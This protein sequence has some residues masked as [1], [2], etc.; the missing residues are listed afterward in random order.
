MLYNPTVGSITL[1]SVVTVLLLCVPHVALMFFICYKLAEKTGVTLW[2]K[3]K[4]K[5]FKEWILSTRQTVQAMENVDVTS[6][7]ESL[8]DR[9]I[10]PE[11]YEPLLPNAN[12][13]TVGESPDS[14]VSI[15]DE[16][17]RLTPVYTYGSMN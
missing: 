3:L 11:D 16:P 1:A 10:N 12:N 5:D 13:C 2:L 4:Y 15:L 14:K 8:P 9:L 6:D 17:R 7:V